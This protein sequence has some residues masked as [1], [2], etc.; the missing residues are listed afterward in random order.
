MTSKGRSD[1][2][3]ATSAPCA[4]WLVLL[5]VPFVGP[6]CSDDRDHDHDDGF[7]E[8]CRYNPET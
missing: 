5:V 2:R 4:A 7:S 3:M 8:E 1:R 6:S